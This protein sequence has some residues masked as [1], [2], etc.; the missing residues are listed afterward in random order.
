MPVLF[1]TSLTFIQIIL[2]TT[3]SNFPP[4][5]FAASKLYASNFSVFAT[6]IK[7]SKLHEPRVGLKC[8]RLPT[9]R[10]PLGFWSVDLYAITWYCFPCIVYDREICNVKTRILFLTFIVELSFC[11]FLPHRKK[12]RT[13]QPIM[14]EFKKNL[15][16]YSRLCSF[17]IVVSNFIWL[18]FDQIKTKFESPNAIE[19]S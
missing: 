9:P 4:G 15:G 12:W 1:A 11:T 7:I 5:Y 13:G 18:C 2:V 8:L 16:Y 14:L 6:S 3:S 19:D 17:I 10:P